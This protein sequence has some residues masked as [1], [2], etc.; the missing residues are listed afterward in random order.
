MKEK[1][2]TCTKLTTKL[3]QDC[4]RAI[5]CNGYLTIATLIEAVN[6]ARE[7]TSKRTSL[8]RLR[9]SKGE[10]SDG[11]LTFLSK[12]HDNAASAHSKWQ[13]CCSKL[14]HDNLDVKEQAVIR[15]GMVVEKSKN[16]ERYLKV[17]LKMETTEKKHALGELLY[18]FQGALINRGYCFG[19][20]HSKP[21]IEDCEDMGSD[22]AMIVKAI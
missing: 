20:K 1:H 5:Q 18:D 15:L 22:A 14:S 10:L 21:A 6:K 19:N 8:H 12:E 17:D 16:V 4:L 13:L 3:A 7:L 11:D 9:K 2:E